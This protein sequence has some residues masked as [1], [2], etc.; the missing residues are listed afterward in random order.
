VANAASVV[1][2]CNKRLVEACSTQSS[3]IYNSM[4]MSTNSIASAAELKVIKQ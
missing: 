1:E 2:S 3:K 4:S